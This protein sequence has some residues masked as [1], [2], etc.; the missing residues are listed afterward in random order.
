MKTKILILFSILFCLLV[1]TQCKKEKKLGTL[2]FTEAEL[3]IVPYKVGDIIVFKDSVGDSF[4]YEVGS[5]NSEMYRY[6]RDPDNVGYKGASDYYDHERN[7]TSLK[8]GRFELGFNDPF[9]TNKIKKYFSVSIKFEGQSFSES[10]EFEANSITPS[11]YHDTLTIV[12]R[13]FNS[14]YELKEYSA[15]SPDNFLLF[16]TFKEGIVG[17]KTNDGKSWYLK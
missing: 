16:Y 15:S 10:Y 3:N 2:K 11:T 5:R 8:D 9:I 4:V 6:Y 13:K 12:N 1:F 17:F 7:N 14:V